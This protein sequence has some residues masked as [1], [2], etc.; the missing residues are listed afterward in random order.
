MQK[1][2]L[3]VIGM[4]L[5]M[6]VFV[7]CGD[8]ISE[9]ED[10]TQIQE[11][12][13]LI[14]Y[15]QEV[16]KELEQIKKPEF[17]AQDIRG[18]SVVSDG[19]ILYELNYTPRQDR[20][21]YLYWDLVTPYASTAI[22]NT[23]EMYELYAQIAAIDFQA[24]E[25]VSEGVETGIADSNTYMVLNYFASSQTEDGQTQEINPNYSFTL[26]IG[27]KT[28]DV[29]YCAIKGYETNVFQLLSEDIE[30]IFSVKPYNLILK[31]PHAVNVATVKE[32]NIFFE[33]KKYEM[34]LEGNTY[35]I[36]GKKTDAGTYCDLYSKL[37]DVM[38]DGEL[39]EED[40]KKEHTEYIKLEYLRNVEY[41]ENYEIIIYELEDG[42]Y[43]VSIN[44][45]ENFFLNQED[46]RILEQSIKDGFEK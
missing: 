24:A 29:Y 41:V 46:V 4:C 22:V 15:P 35:K 1:R 40:R 13:S 37:L 11:G 5:G 28:E 20:D 12:S 45:E 34:L 36:N 3:T 25:L 39:K 30:N 21:S 38:L 17:I 16:A 14:L 9:V 18:I 8:N 26:L 27:N 2:I 43:T 33:D 31:I 10:F 7:A 23:E 42:N 6:S 19:Q 32:V 44:G